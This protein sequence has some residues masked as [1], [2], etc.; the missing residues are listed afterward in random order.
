MKIN[1]TLAHLDIS[2]NALTYQD[3]QIIGEYLKS[4]QSL[5]GIH[6]LGNS[7][8]IDSKGFIVLCNKMRVKVTHL[9]KR[10]SDRQNHLLEAKINC[11]VCEK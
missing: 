1:H 2:Y 9:F 7:C 4:N 6:T 3:C 10:I 5:L 8:S 11:W